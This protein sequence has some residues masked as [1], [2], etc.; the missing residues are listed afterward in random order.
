MIELMTVIV[1]IGVLAAVS[2][3]LFGRYVRKSKTAEA[4]TNIRKIYDGECAY[5]I[6][7]QTTNAGVLSSK[8]FVALPRTPASPTSKKQ[9]ANWNTPAWIAVRFNTDG[10]VL[11]TYEANSSGTGNDA[12]FTAR[13]LGDLDGDGTTSLF[14]RIGAIDA[15]TGDIKGGAALYTLD[16][17]D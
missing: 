10:P 13:A 17:L 7:E 8:Q 6:S 15:A 16:E 2:V 12:A 4:A 1:I 5:Y 9:S 14:E 11:Y 3:P